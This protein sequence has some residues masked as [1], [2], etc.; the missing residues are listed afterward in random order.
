MPAKNSPRQSPRPQWLVI[1]ILCAALASPAQTAL[2]LKNGDRI[3]GK[4]VSED[5]NQVVI[6]TSWGTQQ[7]LPLSLIEKRVELPGA[8]VPPLTNAPALAA[9]N[10]APPPK[11]VAPPVVAKPPKLWNFDIQLGANLEVNQLQSETYNGSLRAN[12]LGPLLRHNICYN[13]SYG[14]ADGVVSANRM[15]GNIRSEYDFT[16]GKRAFVFNA[17]GAGYDTVRKVDITYDESAGVGYKF[18]TMPKL[19]MSGDVGMNYQEQ[20][21]SDRTRTD[22]LSLRVGESLGW[23]VTPRLGI[24]EKAEFYP[25]LT[26]IGDYRVRLEVNTTY[27]LNPLGNIYLNFSVIDVYDTTPAAGVTPNDLQVR[28]TLGLKF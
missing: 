18:L 10:A 2:Q 25:H 15:D 17:V 16:K 28:S 21:F 4:I 23:C 1:F 20:F 3:S 12:Y 9:T 7:T 26:R 5:T 22:Y 27:K 11:I 6:A 8:V 19:S 24:D 14:R 13:G